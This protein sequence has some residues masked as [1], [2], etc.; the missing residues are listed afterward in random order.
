MFEECF[1]AMA[2]ALRLLEFIEKGKENSQNLV[3]EDLR[4]TTRTL[5]QLY[6]ECEE[7]MSKFLML[8]QVM[9]LQQIQQ[10]QSDMTSQ[11]QAAV[12]DQLEKHLDKL[13]KDIAE[14][15]DNNKRGVQ[16]C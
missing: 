4:I 13:R 11:I 3:I 16:K 15:L 2:E 12:S 10:T 8:H 9:R 14:Q 6:E 5:Y 7:E 1:Y